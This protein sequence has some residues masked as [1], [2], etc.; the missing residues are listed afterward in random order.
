[1]AS[2]FDMT[3]PIVS[4][5]GVTKRF[6]AVQALTGVDLDIASGEVTA[7]AGDNGAGKTVLIKT[8]AG[9]WEPDE[10]EILWEGSPVRIRSPKEAEGL[11][12]TTIY[13][14]LALCDNLDVVQNM[15]L[16]HEPREHALLDEPKWS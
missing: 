8:I 7:F 16:G 12:I 13:Q 14:D 3:H 2:E 10:R 4:L 5:R 15:Y 11:G 6:G 9:L 1:M